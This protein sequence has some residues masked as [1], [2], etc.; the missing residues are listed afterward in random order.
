MKGEVGPCAELFSKVFFIFK[1]NIWKNIKMK[2]KKKSLEVLQ[3]TL[4]MEHPRTSI[5]RRNLGIAKSKLLAIPRV[6]P[7]LPPPPAKPVFEPPK[8]GKKKKKKSKKKK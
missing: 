3:K 8:K 4:G 1:V 5:V 2:T 7:A 6:A